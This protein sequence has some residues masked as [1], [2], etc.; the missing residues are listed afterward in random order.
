MESKQALRT[1]YRAQRRN[2][3]ISDPLS[4]QGLLTTPEWKDAKVIASYWSIPY[5]PDT[6][7]LLSATVGKKKILLP[8]VRADLNLEW[9]EWNGETLEERRGLLEPRSQSLGIEAIESADLIIVPALLVDHRGVRLGQGG[10]CFDRSLPRRK[11]EAWT[12][13]LIHK[14]EFFSRDLPRDEFDV[15]VDA[16]SFGSTLLHF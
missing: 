4:S 2:G 15:P 3:P 5:E 7:A 12:V 13:A 16:V 1:T 14:N 9:G 6:H 11:P 10:G 8:I